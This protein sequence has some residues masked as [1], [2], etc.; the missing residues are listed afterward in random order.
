MKSLLAALMILVASPAAAEASSFDGIW[1]PAEELPAYEM[2]Q[3]ER[4][5]TFCAHLAARPAPRAM[6]KIDDGKAQ[7]CR[8]EAGTTSCEKNS[9]NLAQNGAVKNASCQGK[10]TLDGPVN[11]AVDLACSGKQE[12]MQTVQ[13]EEEGYGRYGKAVLQCQTVAQASPWAK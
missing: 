9:L 8:F 2:A 13:V 11:L 3:S 10:F 12:K 5:S 4:L 7:R 6:I 1:L